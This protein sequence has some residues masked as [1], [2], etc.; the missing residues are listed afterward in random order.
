MKLKQL[1]GKLRVKLL[2]V[3]HGWWYKSFII[4]IMRP[5][6]GQML[7][8]MHHQNRV[9]SDRVYDLEKKIELLSHC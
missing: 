4:N 9:L 6:T 5:I 7:L 1:G 2:W 3:W 8:D